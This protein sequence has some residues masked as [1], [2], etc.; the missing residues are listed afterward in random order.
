MKK[1][2]KKIITDICPPPCSNLFPSISKPKTT[3]KVDKI[4][5]KRKKKNIY[6]KL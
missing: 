5:K 6:Q 4:K 3:P 1:K 2:K